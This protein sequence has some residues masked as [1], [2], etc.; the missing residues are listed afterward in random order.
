VL[1]PEMDGC[2]ALLRGLDEGVFDVR[3]HHVNYLPFLSGVTETVEMALKAPL[4]FF[5]HQIWPDPKLTQQWPFAFVELQLFLI[6]DLLFILLLISH[7][8]E[9]ALKLLH[10]LKDF[11]QAFGVLAPVGQLLD[12]HSVIF[13]LGWVYIS[14]KA[15]Y[16]GMEIEP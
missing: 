5:V 3:E 1:Q 11:S 16:G 13:K 8:F 15:G 7:V 4:G 2:D 10:I 9:L 14:D 12:E 6:H